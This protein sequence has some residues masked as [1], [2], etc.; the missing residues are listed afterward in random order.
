MDI[1]KRYENLLKLDSTDINDRN[2]KAMFYLLSCNDD[3]YR[4]IDY[5]YDFNTRDL[6][7][8]VLEKDNVS[9]SYRAI[10]K[11]AFN[12]FNE[13]PVDVS[14]VFCN[15]DSK[16]FDFVVKALEIKYK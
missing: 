16:N 5:I 12:L 9:S 10:I 8:D 15:L 4:L 3:I 1:T 11:L 7:E 13:R 6:I 14:D 2:R